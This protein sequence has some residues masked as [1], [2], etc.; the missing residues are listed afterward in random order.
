MYFDL[1]PPMHAHSSL[2]EWRRAWA[3]FACRGACLSPYAG[4][5]IR[6]PTDDK[7]VGRANTYPTTEKVG[8]GSSAA[9]V[10]RLTVRPVCP[11]LRKCR[12]RS[13]SYVWYQELTPTGPS[14]PA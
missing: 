8:I 7:S 11:Q 4:Y 9:V 14:H 5:L 13:G 2:G 6:K 3:D 12:L 10:A 1:A